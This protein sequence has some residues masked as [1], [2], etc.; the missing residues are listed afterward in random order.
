MKKKKKWDWSWHNGTTL[1]F[2]LTLNP[3]PP[4]PPSVGIYRQY[5]EH[6]IV[7]SDTELE[8]ILGGRDE[9]IRTINGILTD[10][11]PN[12]GPD[13]NLKISTTLADALLEKSLRG[14]LSREA[15]TSF[16]RLEQRDALYKSMFPQPDTG[17]LP[18]LFNSLPPVG[19][20]FS[21]TVYFP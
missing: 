11:G 5:L 1:G 13:L 18:H 14:Q 9:G 15:P 20:G 12:L 3:Q 6:G 8:S 10:F 19:A 7:I 16:D 2:H 4:L 17:F 21:L